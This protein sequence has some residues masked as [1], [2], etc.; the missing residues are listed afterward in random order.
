MIFQQWIYMEWN[1]M[2]YT[3]STYCNL[4]LGPGQT[5]RNRDLTALYSL[6]FV[7]QLNR[8]QFQLICANCKG[9]FRCYPEVRDEK[10]YIRTSWHQNTQSTGLL[11]PQYFIILNKHSIFAKKM[12]S[13]DI[14]KKNIK[15]C[16]MNPHINRFVLMLLLVT[17]YV[18]RN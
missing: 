9:Y 8:M 12:Y 6:C 18:S 5:L 15:N 16:R 4:L 13:N 11:V 17:S 14:E 2:E 3:A 1:G 7:P 10:Y